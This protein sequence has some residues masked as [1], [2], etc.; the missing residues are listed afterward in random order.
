MLNLQSEEDRVCRERERMRRTLHMKDGRC[1]EKHPVWVWMGSLFQGVRCNDNMV[2]TC[3]GERMRWVDTEF[4]MP[5][6]FASMVGNI[7]DIEEMAALLRESNEDVSAALRQMELATNKIRSL[8]QVVSP[9]L[10][11]HIREI[12]ESRMTIDRE[13]K[14][15]LES[16]QAVRDFFLERSYE[17]EMERLKEFISVCKQ[18]KT[19]KDDGT[20]DAVSDLALKLAIGPA[21]L[22]G[23]RA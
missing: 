15:T 13:M 6:Y 1:L 5:S 14:Q 17:K 23:G 4:R 16:L 7:M 20:L 12:R 11:K 3:Y 18:I 10:Q 9:E 19:L 22:T 2:W 21:G 8:Y